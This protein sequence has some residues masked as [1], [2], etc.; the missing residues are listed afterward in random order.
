MVSKGEALSEEVL[1]YGGMW[2]E[3]GRCK[4]SYGKCG[5]MVWRYVGGMVV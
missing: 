3:Y 1:W 5:A 4:L 2:Y